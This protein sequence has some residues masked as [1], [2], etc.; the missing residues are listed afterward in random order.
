MGALSGAD[1]PFAP[2]FDRAVRGLLVHWN[3]WKSPGMCPKRSALV[4]I[5]GPRKSMILSSFASGQRSHHP[6]V[7]CHSGADAG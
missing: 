1:H 6:H 5:A 2:R 4:V 3:G 7:R